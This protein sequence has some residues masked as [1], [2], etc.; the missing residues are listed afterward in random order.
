MSKKIEQYS[1]IYK[2]KVIVHGS[3]II[4][5]EEKQKQLNKMKKSQ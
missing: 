1:S 2:N 3:K 5:T 4:W